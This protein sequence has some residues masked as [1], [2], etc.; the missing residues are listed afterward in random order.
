MLPEKL[1]IGVY[2]VS[3]VGKSTLISQF[4]KYPISTFAT[5]GSDIIDKITEGGLSEFKKS[6]NDAKFKIRTQA[7]KKLFELFQEN[8]KHLLVAGH[9]CFLTNNDFEIV[10][11][12]SD[13]RFY[14]IIFYLHKPAQFIWQQ[15]YSD[16]SRK[17]TFSENDLDQWQEFEYEKLVS[18]C[19]ENKIRLE[20]LDGTLPIIELEKSMIKIISDETIQKAGR[21]IISEKNKNVMLLDCDGT[22]NNQ[23][24][25]DFV[26]DDCINKKVISDIFKKYGD[27]CFDAYY[28]VSLLFSK[29]N[30][31]KI[32]TTVE[33][34]LYIHSKIKKI[35]ELAKS[36]GW[37]VIFIS[38]GFPTFWQK[39]C[40][41]ANNVLGGASFNDYG[42]I[43]T[44]ENKA[45]LAFQL[46]ANGITVSSFGNGSADFGMLKNS[47]FGTFVFSEKI[48][49][50]HKTM[51][52]SLSHVSTISLENGDQS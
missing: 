1:R 34:Q 49:D 41:L 48:K 17:R 10:W 52:D 26:S 45:N 28:E 33:S 8:D 11:T 21:N 37:N 36:Q 16:S 4:K 31:N 14:E 5:D 20:K 43:L 35:I 29:L 27:Y 42:C 39:S 46:K 47:D 40:H 51:I 22:L 38:S 3:G 30:I 25:L 12:E 13:S 7:S 50:S 6:T 32:F 19:K 44:N 15:Q 9:F 23:D 24:V 2:G 18:I